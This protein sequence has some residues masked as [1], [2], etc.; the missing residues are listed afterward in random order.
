MSRLFALILCLPLAGCSALCN[1]IGDYEGTFKGDAEGDFTLGISDGGDKDNPVV[2]AAFGGDLDG[3]IASGTISCEDGQFVLDIYIDDT[4]QGSFE[5]SM[6]DN[7]AGNGTWEVDD[8]R[9][10]TWDIQ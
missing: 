3:A 6:Q 8:G 4:P 7:T 1:L 10:G 5:G 9:S 2:A